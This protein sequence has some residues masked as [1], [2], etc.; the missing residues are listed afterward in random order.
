MW[1]GIELLRTKH[2]YSIQALV[3]PWDGIAQKLDT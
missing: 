2:V 3:A 1:S